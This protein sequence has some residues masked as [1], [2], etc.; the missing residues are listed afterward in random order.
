MAD[1][2]E[3][4]GAQLNGTTRRGVREGVSDDVIVAHVHKLAKGHADV[5]RRESARAIGGW[6]GLPVAASD[7]RIG[8]PLLEASAV[9]LADSDEFLAEVDAARRR[10]ASLGHGVGAAHS[11]QPPT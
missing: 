4:L 3:I 1:P 8:Y 2:F 7:L 6:L 5:L 11:D 9:P 10:V